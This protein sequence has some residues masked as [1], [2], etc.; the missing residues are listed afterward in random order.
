MEAHRPID[1]I[2]W[3]PHLTGSGEKVQPSIFKTEEKTVEV[4]EDVLHY[5]VFSQAAR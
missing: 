2:V 1:V 4:I 3:V 5:E